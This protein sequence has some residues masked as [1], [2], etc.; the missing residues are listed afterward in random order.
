MNLTHDKRQEN[1]K[2]LITGEMQYSGD[3]INEVSY[4]YLYPVVSPIASG[5]LISIDFSE[6]EKMDGFICSYTAEDIPGKN[7]IGAVAREEEPLLAVDTVNYVGQP[8]GFVICKTQEQARLAAKKVKVNVVS[9]GKEILTIKEA[10]KK[11]SFY[12]EPLVIDSGNIEKEFNDSYKIIEGEFRTGGQEHAYIETQRAFASYTS[13]KKAILI[14]CGTQAITDIQEVVA[15]NLGIRNNEVEV[16]VYRVGGA[17]GGKERGGTMWSAM[18]ALAL[19]K[20]KHACGVVLDRSDDIIWTGKRH[21]YYS[22]YKLGI[23]NEGK[24]KAL[25]T[26]MYADGGY[27]EDFT[28]AIMERAILGLCNGYYFASSHIVGYCCK[29]NL[30]ANT[31][32]RG[33]G[34]P[35]ATLLMEEMIYQISHVTKKD[36]SEIQRLNFFKDGDK[37]HYGMEMHE[38]ALPKMYDKLLDDVDYE[39]LRLETD[40]YNSIHRYSKKGIG[41]VPIKYGIGFTATFLNQGNAL[42]YIY[43]DGSVSVS[44]GGIEMGQGLFTKLELIVA[45]TL[46]IKPDNVTCESTN[47]LRAG[48]VA[49]TAASTGTDLNGAAARIAALNIKKSLTTAASMYLKEKYDL[50]PA[51]KYIVFKEGLWWDERMSTVK[52]SFES[53][54]SYCY[55]NRYNMGAQGH[56]ATPGLKYDAKTGKGT[57]FAYFTNGVCLCT[58]TVD[59]LTGSYTL[60]K[61]AIRH[62]GGHILDYDIDRGQI[63]GGFVQGMGFVTMEELPHAGNGSQLA[64]S[65]STYKVPLI[66]DLP[67]DFSLE[68]YESDNEQSAVL[69]SKGVGEPP[70]NYGIAAFNAIRDA[71]GATAKGKRVNLNQPATPMEVLLTINKLKEKS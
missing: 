32:F 63:L 39:N 1:I 13:F 50:E 34:A 62:E 38:V 67:K 16:D 64:S 19:E 22:T 44:H 65:F 21:P 53:L 56:Y 43:T 25:E 12:T 26:H 27:Y 9:D 6:A 69:G 70:L 29:T 37:A 33:F 71:I 52:T 61:V 40:K 58:A 28:F 68:L 7:A 5:K 23:D 30:P 49:S 20:T 41:I 3:L 55:F 66:N 2:S 42:V 47:S 51:E 10:I 31:A 57:P 45:E 59:V 4:N 17:F 15:L 46:G 54:A 14:H 8:V 60:D 18:A 11:K 24:I 36:V 48:S 35:Q